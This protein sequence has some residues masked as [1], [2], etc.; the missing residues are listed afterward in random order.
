[1]I[2]ATPQCSHERTKKA[3]VTK[4]GTQRHKCLNCGKRFTAS[5]VLFSGMRVGIEKAEQIL[6][7]LV[8]GMSVRATARLTATD[9][10][11]VL[12]L[13]LLVGFRCKKFLESTIQG[14]KV[15]DVQCD[16][17]HQFIYCRR[18]TAQRL[19]AIGFGGPCG[20]SWCFTAVERHSKLMIAW[21]FGGRYLTDTIEFCRK[22]RHAT[23]GHFHLSTDGYQ[24]YNQAV[25]M[26]FAGQVDYGQLVKIFSRKGEDSVRAYAPPKIV[27]SRKEVVMGEPDKARICTSHT[28]RQNGSIRLFT[29]RMN[30]LTYAFSKKFENHEAALA[31]YFA[32]YNFCRKH[33]SLYVK[34]QGARTP[35]MAAGL[36]DHA[37]TVAELLGK[38]A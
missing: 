3:G 16:E 10:Q 20:D 31:L 22:L 36:T 25:P 37:W 33:G 18:R 21:H 38:I 19:E 8:E 32:H 15:D 12:D 4:A 29:K 34:S 17:I 11:T 26:Y 27:S 9:P 28:E 5:T 24:T 7:M 35:A 23:S 2:D 1:V 13:L 14:V 6:G 30:R